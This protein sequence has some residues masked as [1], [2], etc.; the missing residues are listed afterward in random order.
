MSALKTTTTELPESRVRVEAQVSPDA[1]QKS[2]ERAAS[3]IG[4][5]MRIPGFRKGKVPAPVII[6]RVG[7]EVVLDEAVR[8]G[9]TAW[10]V[11]AIDEAGISPVGDPDL[12]LGDLPDAGAPWSFTFEIGVLPT[13]TLGTYKGV[14]VGKADPAA[15]DEDVQRQLDE[16]RERSGTLETADRAAQEGD[17]T[18]IDFVGKKDGVPFEGG[19][20]RDFP[21]ELGSDRFIPGFEEQLV[22]AK[23]GDD[24]VVEVTFPE[25][26]QAEHLAGEAVTF[27]VTVKEVKEKKLPE[28]DDEFAENTAGFDTLDELR[29]E[30]AKD[31][32]EK[33]EARID[34]AFREAAL[35][36]AV[37]E[38]TV[39]VPEALAEARGK[40]LWE[41]MMHQLS[42]QGI[43]KE[44]YLQISGRTEE[45]LMAEA[46]PDAE[47]QLRRE[48]VLKAI[49]EAEKFE[50][51]DDDLLEALAPTAE[52]QQT[53]PKKLL[54]QL[55]SSGRIDEARD[56][57]AQRKAMDLVADEAKTITVAQA[58]KKGVPFTPEAEADG[59]SA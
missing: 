57:L 40:E 24:V 43:S 46:A 51:T 42:H 2:L 28:L 26:Y 37:A 15:A 49:I 44:M 7:R 17:F 55:K 16:L 38:A 27:E 1:V 58:K 33:E 12:D 45:E 52:A 20:G 4:R 48:A 19:E 6:Q 32:R 11:E 29:E 36:A 10:Y 9:L 3:A 31:L 41:R 22:G 21:L 50:I 23:A 30:I 39:E 34:R 18:T 59:P 35:D 53:K 47:Q 13:A 54:D 8:D 5:D 14:E 25:D 56:D